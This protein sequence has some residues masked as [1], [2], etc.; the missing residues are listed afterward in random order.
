MASV[1]LTILFNAIFFLAYVKVSPWPP[2]LSP[3]KSHSNFTT[4]FEIMSSII[5]CLFKYR[6]IMRDFSVFRLKVFYEFPFISL[7]RRKRINVSD[8]NYSKKT[9]LTAVR[10]INIISHKALTATR[11][12][13]IFGP[14][15]RQILQIPP[16]T[17]H[18]GISF[19]QCLPRAKEILCPRRTARETSPA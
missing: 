11:V 16:F 5:T 8:R 4:D 10:D 6:N 13:K 17:Y 19:L 9:A 7:K 14:H 12:L 15:R 1:I 18:S 2:R 3:T